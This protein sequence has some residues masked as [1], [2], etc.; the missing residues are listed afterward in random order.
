V[1]HISQS[2]WSRA[3]NILR[4][5]MAMTV[6]MVAY[7]ASA[8][9]DFEA[10][11][12]IVL[13]DTLVA[14][15]SFARDIQPILTARCA[16]ASCHTFVTMQ[17]DLALDS[18]HSYAQLVNVEAKLRS[19]KVRVLPGNAADSWLYNMISEDSTERTGEPRMPLGRTPLTDNQI[20]TIV[21]WINQGAANN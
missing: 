12:P 7:A 16:T 17:G 15:P 18:A 11:D 10:P 9:V 1:I 8:C 19:G 6:L 13:P 5:A 14:Q 21:N 20:G 4:A 2:V 3:G